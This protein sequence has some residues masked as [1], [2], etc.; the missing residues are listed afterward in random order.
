MIIMEEDDSSQPT[1]PVVI[2]DLEHQLAEAQA[3]LEQY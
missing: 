3:E 1:T 2:K